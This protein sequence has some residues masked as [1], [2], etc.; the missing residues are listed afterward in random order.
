[1]SKL[2]QASKKI[3]FILG[4]IGK[5]VSGMETVIPNPQNSNTTSYILEKWSQNV[6]QIKKLYNDINTE[7]QRTEYSRRIYIYYWYLVVHSQ[8]W[9]ELQLSET[10]KIQLN[11]FEDLIQRNI[12]E[13]NLTPK[14]SDSSYQVGAKQYQVN[15]PSPG[16]YKLAIYNYQPNEQETILTFLNDEPYEFRKANEKEKWYLGDLVNLK[17]GGQTIV[18]PELS[19][20]ELAYPGFEL[21]Q[22]PGTPGCEQVEL[23]KIDP[24]ID[25]DL[26][27]EYETLSDRHIKIDLLEK[28]S[29]FPEGK[30]K[31]I[32]PV[33]NRNSTKPFWYK[34]NIKYIPSK[35][36]E[37]AT[38]R[39]CIK[40][41]LS[42]PTTLDYNSIVG[43]VSLPTTL[44][45]KSI[46][47]TDV[48][49]G[50]P[51]FIIQENTSQ[52]P[53]DYKLQ[54]VALNQTAYLVLVSGMN[55]Q[56][57][58]NFNSRFDQQWVLKKVNVN[59]AK[60]Y[61]KGEQKSYLGGQVIEYERQDKHVLSGLMFPGDITSKVP[62]I[63]LNILSNGWSIT[64]DGNKEEAYL[65]E[66][67][68]QKIFYK[69]GAIS[70]VF[71]IG[72]L[73]AYISIRVVKKND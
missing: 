3:D 25:Y 70:L 22:P 12:Q 10:I 51:V 47:M 18:L 4:T 1:M 29:D 33:I 2:N 57:I 56:S 20:R 46:K 41:N 31:S 16:Q 7:D 65:I 28:N 17:E 64:P 55:R 27:F 43:S 21:K 39:F 38:L 6:E 11:Q 32:Y 69:A 62:D 35:F 72:L 54:F 13:L 40:G 24:E 26:E 61:F 19:P 34:I 59:T 73:L 60:Q 63:E 30:E 15:I 37:N 71:L 9:K 49:P 58:L 45:V 48:Y 50:S 67:T 52:V 8:Q 36:V 66:Y 42:V 23:G 5:E 68:P 14:I 44:D 53:D